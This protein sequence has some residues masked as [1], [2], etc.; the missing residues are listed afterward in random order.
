MVVDAQTFKE[1]LSHWA[2]GVSIVGAMADDR[3]VGITASSLASLSVE[4]P[5]VLISVNKRLF[6]HEAIL[7]TQA[8]SVSILREDQMEWGMR[9]AGMTPEMADR[10]AGIEIVTAV[11][12]SP[13][14]RE[15]LAWLDCRVCRTYDGDD[16]TIFVGE[17]AAAHSSHSGKPLLYYDRHWRTLASR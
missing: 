17:V 9:F 1:T 4:P 7:K 14:L 8:F 12:G 13:I 2:T 11:T 3:P 15:S 16:H 5:Q 6:T 10:F